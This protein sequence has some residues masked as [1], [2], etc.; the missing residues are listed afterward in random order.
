MIHYISKNKIVRIFLPSLFC[1]IIFCS[2]S[3][4]SAATGPTVL[5]TPG[6]GT[7]NAVQ[8]VTLAASAPSTIYYTTDGSTPTTSSTN[9][10]SPVVLIVNSNSTLKFFAKDSGGN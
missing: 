10:P 6:G 3:I 5:P 1:V 4:A 9:G 2:Y 7:Y 8:S